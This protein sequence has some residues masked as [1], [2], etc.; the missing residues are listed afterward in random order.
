MSDF[1]M[2]FILTSYGIINFIYSKMF[3][4]FPEAGIKLFNIS[5]V[6]MMG[7]VVFFKLGSWLGVVV[8]VIK[9][10]LRKYILTAL[11]IL[12]FLNILS[13]AHLNQI[14]ILPINEK[15]F[16]YLFRFF[17][18]VNVVFLSSLYAQFINRLNYNRE[19]KNIYTT[20]LFNNM[21]ITPLIWNILYY[22]ISIEYLL[23]IIN[24]VVFFNIIYFTIN[25]QQIGNLLYNKQTEV[26]YPNIF[27][28]KEIIHRSYKVYIKYTI[29]IASLLF[30]LMPVLLAATVT[31]D[32]TFDLGTQNIILLLCYKN[33]PYLLSIVIFL[34]HKYIKPSWIFALVLL[35]GF[36]NII[37]YSQIFLL[38]NGGL[39]YGLYLLMN[40]LVI[41]KINEVTANLF[42]YG[43]VIFYSFKNIISALLSQFFGTKLLHL[44]RSKTYGVECYHLFL[45]LSII[46]LYIYYINVIEKSEQITTKKNQ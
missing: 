33:I 11:L 35:I 30:V 28:N 40:N 29:F 42:Y 4:L 32:K 15:Y 12:F 3:F 1:F 9:I 41:S 46:S 31:D 22:Y 37:Y 25:Y 43:T 5:I 39:V 7:G 26:L 38:I 2:Y 14:Y 17:T 36:C 20:L 27:I 34:F 6:T 18:G 44:M 19:H 24:I 16:F 21:L 8:S 23:V 13:I 10:E 45:I